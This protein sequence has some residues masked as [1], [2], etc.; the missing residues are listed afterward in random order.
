MPLGRMRQWLCSGAVLRW[1]E[2]SARL[3]TPCPAGKR[4]VTEA[5]T[6]LSVGSRSLGFPGVDSWPGSLLVA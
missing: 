3:P 6:A 2:R 1:A 5:V 4:P